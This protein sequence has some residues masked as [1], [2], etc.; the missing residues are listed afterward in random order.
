M[1]VGQERDVV[2]VL[3]QQT[4][5]LEEIGHT[6]VKVAKKAQTSIQFRTLANA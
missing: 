3:A 4:D 2:H 1:L 5:D 6:V